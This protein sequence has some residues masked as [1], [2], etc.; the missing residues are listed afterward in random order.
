M[1]TP[2]ARVPTFDSA[3]GKAPLRSLKA[4]QLAL[5]HGKNFVE[6]GRLRRYKRPWAGELVPV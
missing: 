5:R 2:A 1:R 4:S 3:A 6:A